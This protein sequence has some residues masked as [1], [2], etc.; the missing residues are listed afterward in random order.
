MDVYTKFVSSF[1]FPLHERVKGHHTTRVLQRLEKS[2]W[3]SRESIVEVQIR[4]LK[5]FLKDISSS[6]PYYRE[7]FRACS[8]NPDSVSEL[9]DLQRLPFLDKELIKKNRERLKST[10][11]VGLRRFNTGGSTGEP[12]IFYLNS[13]RISHDI[14]A[15]WRATRWWHVDIGDPEVVLWGSPIELQAQDHMRRWR[16]RLLRSTL[17]SAFDLSYESLDRYLEII[18]RKKPRMLFGYPSVIAKLAEHARHRN[19]DMGDSGVKV[20]FVTAE[21]LYPWQ[22]DLIRSVFRCDVANGY[23]GRDA[24][25]VAHECPQGSMH[26][27]AEDIIVEIIDD[28]GRVLPPGELGEIV[29]THLRTQAFPFLRYRTGDMGVLSNQSCS[30]GRGLPVLHEISG[31]STDFIVTRGGRLVH[32][33]AL[34]YV[35]RDLDEVRSFKIT[36]ETIQDLHIDLVPGP[37]FGDETA[38]LIESKIQQAAGQDFS[39]KI[40]RVENI[41][42]E[43]SGKYRYVVSKVHN[44]KSDLE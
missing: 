26:I 2:Q 42:P 8:F 18:C 19:M 11:A 41:P 17:L 23:G 21:K 29:I 33:L 34:I 36:Q 44:Q 3:E 1:L 4:D 32:G 40:N 31:R 27:T 13:E 14:A 22:R 5:A 37:G 15:K 38:K 25:F 24:G 16:D 9:Y 7:L 10:R 43:R 39:V 35:L 30:C 6:V 20:A 28:S 12:L